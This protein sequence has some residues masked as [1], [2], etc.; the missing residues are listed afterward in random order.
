MK[1]RQLSWARDSMGELKRGRQRGI[2]GSLS[3]YIFASRG[4]LFPLRVLQRMQEHTTFSQV[5]VPPLSRGTTWSRLSYFVS[6]RS[7][8]Y[9]QV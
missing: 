6:N 1:C 4:S 9:W 8:Q 2:R 3:G 5:V 7:A